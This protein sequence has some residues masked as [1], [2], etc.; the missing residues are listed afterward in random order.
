MS[1]K[2][3]IKKVHPLPGL[4]LVKPQEVENRTPSGIY[5]PESSTEKPQHGTVLAV[6][7]S[8]WESGVKEIT[9]PVEPVTLPNTLILARSLRED[10]G[11]L[12][13]PPVLPS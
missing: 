3:S 9:A 6:G 12:G 1:Q 8:I 13:P 10:A 4:V 2:I 7:D 5:L 11:I